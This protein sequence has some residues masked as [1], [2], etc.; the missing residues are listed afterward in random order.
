MT[1]QF[2]ALTV[3]ILTQSN[4]P[5]QHRGRGPCGRALCLGEEG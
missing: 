5:A 2:Q 3:M 1:V 4:F